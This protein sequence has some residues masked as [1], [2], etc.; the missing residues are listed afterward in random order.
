MVL[1]LLA[2]T[3]SHAVIIPDGWD[4]TPYVEFGKQYQT[5]LLSFGFL[6][7]TQRRERYGTQQTSLPHT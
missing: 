7:P 1:T 4:D 2:A 6:E 3:A 5:N